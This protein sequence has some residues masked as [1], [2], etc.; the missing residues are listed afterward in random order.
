[1]NHSMIPEDIRKLSRERAPIFYQRLTMP[2]P[3]SIERGQIWSTFSH[4]TL[5]DG[6]SFE[7]D[8]PRIVLILAAGD[9]SF[10]LSGQ[11]IVA[12]I[13]IHTSMATELDLICR[14]GA[15]PLGFEFIVEVWNE[16]PALIKQLRKYLGRLSEPTIEVLQELYS[17]HLTNAPVPGSLLQWVGLP[18][19]GEQD[20]RYSF[21]E[22]EVEAA[23]YL[24]NAATAA[25]SIESPT[26][27]K[28]K[29][30]ILMFGT[31]K[32]FHVN[33]KLGRLVDV[34]RGPA[35]AHAA[36]KDDSETVLAHYEGNNEY[37][38]IELLWKQRPPYTIYALIHRISLNLE[39]HKAI[40]S[41]RSSRNEWRSELVEVRNNS[42]I[43]IA[44]DSGFDLAQVE[45]FD[46]EIEA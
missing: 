26:E 10:D 13:S 4:I 42:K 30:N 37:F 12:P 28:A 17:C 6:S 41:L 44:Q 8:D 11:V 19:M 46:L 23:A 2:T 7:T 9:T 3:D 31:S 14:Q 34:L 16:T 43:P 36:K 25:L 20:P 33:P 27:E 29:S 38:T 45:L 21:Q 39:G 32:T 22:G 35:I 15:S 1:M 18:L 40:I 5:S 24:A